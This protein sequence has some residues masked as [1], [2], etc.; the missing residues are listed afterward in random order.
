MNGPDS[1]NVCVLAHVDHGKTSL[2]DGLIASNGI[3]SSRLA[4]QLRYMDSRDDEQDRGIT[5][6][7]SSIA[8]VYQPEEVAAAGG[9]AEAASP[10]RVNLI[11]SPGHVD[12]CSEV[13]SAVRLSDGALLVVDVV[14][15]VCVQTAAVLRQAW[16]EGVTP[17]LVLNKMDR[18]V[19]ELRLSPIEAWGHIKRILGQLNAIAGQFYTADRLVAEGGAAAA[20]A[21]GGDS[22]GGDDGGGGGGGDGGGDGGGSGGGGSGGGGVEKGVRELQFS[23]TRGNVLFA[24]AAHG[25]AFDLAAFARQYAAKLGLKE[26]TLQRTLWGEECQLT[27]DELV[28]RRARCSGPCGGS[29]FTSRRRSGWSRATRR[30]G[31]SQCSPSLSSG[32]SGAS[33]RRRCSSQVRGHPTIS[34]HLPISP[35]VSVA[36]SSARP[37]HARRPIS[38]HLPTSPHISPYL[39]TSP[40][41]QTPRSSPRWSARS[42]CRCRRSS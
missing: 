3:I 30:A 36:S 15:G 24:S 13:S 25:W 7:A 26:S 41:A 18:L 37:P 32:R 22:G 42:G 1:R 35:H 4:G 10:L 27:I 16:D 38:P 31:S 12:F 40:F 14:E 29:T 6:K 28:V 21:T 8:L 20:L 23:P 19:A 39:P 11:D 5:M 33:T 9:G 34:P 17:L 2:S